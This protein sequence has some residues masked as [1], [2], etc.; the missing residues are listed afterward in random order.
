MDE[1]L[2]ELL[3][4]YDEELSRLKILPCQA[5]DYCGEIGV[6][7]LKDNMKQM[8]HIRWMMSQMLNNFNKHDELDWK[9]DKIN[10]WLGFIQGILWCNKMRGIKEIKKEVKCL[11]K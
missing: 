10:R 7:G 11:T 3:I 4:Q 6:Q 2:K 9:E 1:Q 5:K 8:A